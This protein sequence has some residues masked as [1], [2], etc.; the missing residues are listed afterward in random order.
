MS[1]KKRQYKKQQSHSVI[2]FLQ[3]W[4]TRMRNII[5]D[6]QK[7]H[8]WIGSLQQWLARMQRPIMDSMKSQEQV[9]IPIKYK[10]FLIIPSLIAAGIILLATSHFG[11]GVSSDS[12]TYISVARNIVKGI[13]LVDYAGANLISFPPLYP[14]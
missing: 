5:M 14:A 8:S 6:Y 4:L 9:K 3:Q 11:V 7:S 2:G 1:P 12:V 13:G 10:L